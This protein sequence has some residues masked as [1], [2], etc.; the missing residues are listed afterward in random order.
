MNLPSARTVTFGEGKTYGLDG[1]GFL[2][3]P[4]QWDEDFA[5]GMARLQGIYDGLTKEHWDFISYIREKFL[6]ENTLPL[7]VVACA[8]NHLRLSKLKS[9]FPTGY[10]RGACRIAGVSYQFLCDVNIWHTYEAPHRL[11]P[12][13][14]ISPQGFLED[15]D[16][17]NER[18]AELVA[19]KWNL[20]QGL[21]S[22]HWEVIHFLRNYY[23]TTNNIPTVYEVCQAHNL[24][25][26]DLG[27]LFPEGYRRGACRAAGL[28]F[29][30]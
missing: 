5:N 10:F 12:E 3:Q 29:F 20:P 25:L 18:F 22:K 4:Q 17:W 9:L 30:A 8:D 16:Q 7:L 13:Y 11:K 14:S 6:K 19:D 27:K 2:E 23:K 15:F 28:P 26:A 24:D 21:T 1:Y